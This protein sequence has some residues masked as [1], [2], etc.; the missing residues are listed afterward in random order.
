MTPNNQLRGRLKTNL[1]VEIAITAHFVRLL[2]LFGLF[3]ALKPSY[4]FL[5]KPPALVF[6]LLRSEISKI[7]Q[8]SEC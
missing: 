1:V 3:M 4:V 8:R 2:D 6:Q 5:V 7:Q